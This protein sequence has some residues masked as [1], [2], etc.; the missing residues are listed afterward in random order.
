MDDEPVT[1]ASGNEPPTAVQRVYAHVREA[2]LSGELPEGTMLSEN[3]VAADLGVSRTPVREAFVQLQSQGFLRL[4]PRRGALVVPVSRE[5]IDAVI[6]TRWAVERHAVERLAG[7]PGA[8]A[9]TDAI[10]AMQAAVDRQQALL[11]SGDLATFSDTDREFHRAAVAATGNRILL[12]LYDTLRDRQRRM[13]RGS[14]GD[15][16]SRAQVVL[17]EHREI[18]AAIVSGDGPHATALLQE[19][20]DGSRRALFG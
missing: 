16:S 14:V 4:Y 20:L 6:E 2:V 19:H 10:T 13:V 7:A 1:A 15:D 18:L 11:D 5:E 8:A 12:E 3:A 17:D 9:T